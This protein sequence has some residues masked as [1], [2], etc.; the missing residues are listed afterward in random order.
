MVKWIVIGIT[1]IFILIIILMGI[2]YKNQEVDLRNQAEAQQKANKVIYDK[3]WKVIQQKAQI[4]DKYENAF[5][6]I[7]NNLMTQ[8]YQGDTKNNPLFKFITEQH[9]NLS[10]DLYKDLSDA[11]E[12]NRAEFARVQNR[13]IDIKREHQNLRQKFPSSI[14]VGGKSEL[15]IQTVTSG[16][17][18]EVFN[19]GQENDIKLF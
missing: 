19:I 9:P 15:I 16:K 18:E 2:G 3:V 1:L 11:V 17:T 5:K 4:S 7:Y 14:F 13:L 12:S 10:T 8:R 6:E